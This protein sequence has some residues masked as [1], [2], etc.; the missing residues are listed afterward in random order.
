[1][2]EAYDALR[3][4]R[5]LCFRLYSASREVTRLYR[6]YLDPLG[7][8]YPQ[9]LV[10]LVL[11]ESAEPL[12]VGEL[13]QRLALESNPLTPMLKKLE[14]IGYVSRNRCERDERVLLVSVTDAGWDLRERA[15]EVPSCVYRAMGVTDATAVALVETLDAFS[16]ELH[17]RYK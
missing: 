15:L 17:E 13:G 14:T 8:T 1:M 12:S 10:M 11:W 5:Q 7:L 6:P 9:Y 2:A 3:L 4:D 16:A